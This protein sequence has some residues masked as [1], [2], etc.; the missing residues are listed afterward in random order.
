M[1]AWAIAGGSVVSGLLGADAAG[2]Q[3]DAAGDATRE[4]TRQFDLTW[5]ANAPY[6][7]AGVNALANLS[8]LTGGADPR[9]QAAIDELQGYVSEFRRQNPKKIKQWTKQ[10]FDIDEA[11]KQT[12]RDG[13]FRRKQNKQGINRI[14]KLESD[15][16]TYD[17]ENQL[18]NIEDLVKSDPSY[19]FRFKEGEDATK[20]YLSGSNRRLGGTSLKALTD[21][22]QNF[23]STEYGNIF[24]RNATIAG[25][26]PSAN[27]T[28]QN[29]IP[30]S[31]I[32][33]GNAA[34][35]K[36]SAY[37]NAIQGGI[38]NYIAYDAQNALRMP[39]YN[40][41]YSIPMTSTSY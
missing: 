8:M 36:Y 28:P 26:G 17:P 32:A 4:G 3:A 9:Y 7:E 38:Q 21:Y 10:G 25:F 12:L 29:V 13:D 18:Q 40:T 11:I 41:D 14:A 24:N 35:G 20:N 39:T 2:E 15:I 34:A 5:N 22:G 30:Q 27:Q 16:A 33:Q 1:S 6:R 31:M 19:D 37:N 23:A